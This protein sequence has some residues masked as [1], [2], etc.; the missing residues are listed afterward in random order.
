MTDY[1]K[2]FGQNAPFLIKEL[3][4]KVQ[5]SKV[6]RLALSFNYPYRINAIGKKR[7]AIN[8]E[9]RT[10]NLLTQTDRVSNLCAIWQYIKVYCH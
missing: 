7:E 10:P 3:G 9:R 4:S 2:Y 8:L 1:W 5:C 6:Q